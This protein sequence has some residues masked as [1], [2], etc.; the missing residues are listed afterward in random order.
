MAGHSVSN[1][2][3]DPASKRQKMNHEPKD[4]SD[5]EIEIVGERRRAGSEE[6]EI[7]GEKSTRKDNVKNAVVDEPSVSDVLKQFRW[8]NSRVK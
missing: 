4:D 8:D 7:V 6:V 1:V 2:F 3:V 5:D